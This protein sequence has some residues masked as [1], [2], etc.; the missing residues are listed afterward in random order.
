MMTPDEFEQSRR[1]LFSIAYRMLGSASEAEDV[2]QDAWLRYAS[3]EPADVRSPRAYLTTIVTRLALDRLKSARAARERYVGPW[4]PEPVLTEGQPEPERSVVLAESLTLAFMVLLDTLSPEERAV[5]LLR[6]IFEYS[7]AEIASTLPMTESNCRQLY[8]RAKAR[9]ASGRERVGRSQEEKQK[10]A[11]RFAAAMRAGD[12][13]ELTRVLAEDV[14]FWGDGGGRAIAARRPVLGRDAVLNLLVGIRRTARSAGIDL[15]AVS[16]DLVE[17]NYEP[18]MV[19]RLAGLIDSVYTFS[20]V[21]GAITGIR[22]VRN[23]DKLA[24]IARQMG[25]AVLSQK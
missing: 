1:R 4:L 14:G 24:Y 7:Y 18:A 21:E 10:L 11:E 5:F 16:M 8:H 2:V 13:D 25:T 23:P 6:E 19:V 9:V 15:E 12:R 20:I 3:A 22:V 17:V